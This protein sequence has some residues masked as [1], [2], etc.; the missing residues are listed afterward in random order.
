[1]NNIQSNYIPVN[2]EDTRVVMVNTRPCKK[3]M[4]NYFYSVFHV[5]LSVFAI[6]LS[7]R[8]NKQGFDVFHFVFAL[9]C[10]LIYILFIVATR[11]SCGLIPSERM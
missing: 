5:I 10:P 11:G 6:Y 8:C 4:Y 7:F 3:E 2:N 1:M 9:F